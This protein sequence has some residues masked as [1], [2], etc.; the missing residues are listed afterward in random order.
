MPFWPHLNHLFGI[1]E[2]LRVDAQNE[3]QDD[4]C[5]MKAN[6]VKMCCL[7]EALE[8]LQVAASWAPK[9]PPGD[10]PGRPETDQMRQQEAQ[11]APKKTY[12]RPISTLTTPKSLLDIL[13]VH[14]GV[15]QHRFS[16]KNIWKNNVF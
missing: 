11:S 8:T 2:A 6:L 10:P 16:L 9:C 15:C 3:L 13:D 7:R 1:W 14:F 4:V 5:K 12:R